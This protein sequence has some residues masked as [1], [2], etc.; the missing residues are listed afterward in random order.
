MV[1]QTLKLLL[2]LMI[3][4]LHIVNLIFNSLLMVKLERLLFKSGIMDL[5][6]TILDYIF[7]FIHVSLLE[8]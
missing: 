2:F 8:E 1:M 4:K 5:V 6:T 7:I 3:T